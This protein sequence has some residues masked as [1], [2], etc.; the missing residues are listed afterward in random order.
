MLLYL[1]FSGEPKA[2]QSF[3]FTRA[4]RKYQPKEVVE[5][6]NWIKLQALRRIEEIRGFEKFTGPVSVTVNFVFPPLKSFSKKKMATLV[7]GEKIYKTTKP[8]L[9]DNLMKGLIDALSG[10]IWDRDQQ[11]VEVVSMKVYGLEAKTEVWV[12]EIDRGL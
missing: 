1:K 4:G 11:I 6:K 10:I 3:R 12:K 5:W 8:D 7:A 2:V 9:S